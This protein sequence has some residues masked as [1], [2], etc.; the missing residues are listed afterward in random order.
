V[1]DAACTLSGHAREA[2]VGATP[3]IFRSGRHDRAFFEHMWSTI[4]SGR[5]WRGEI[6]NRRA[7]GTVCPEEMTITPVRDGTG[8]IRHYVAVKQDVTDRRA[9][10]EA[11][12]RSNEELQQALLDL[13]A[14]ETTVIRQERLRALGSLASGVAHDFNNALTAILGYSEM[15]LRRPED[16]SD[17]ETVRRN[18]AV[19]RDAAHDAGAVVARLREFYRPPDDSADLDSVDL[20][21]VVRGAVTLS[22]PRWKNEA[23]ARGVRVSV[24]VEGEGPALVAG[25]PAELREAVLNLILNAV[26]ALPEGGEIVLRTS[27]DGARVALDVEDTGVGMTD[28]ARARC[29]E[30]FFSTKGDRGTGLGLAMVHGIVR[31]HGGTID[32]ESERGAGTRF[33]LVFPAAATAGPR[34][35]QDAGPEGQRLRILVVD[36]DSRT[37]TVV[38]AYLDSLGHEPVAAASADDAL[39]TFMTSRIDL[40]VIDRA[41]PGMNGDLLASLLR[42][43]RPDLP[44]IMLTGFGSM[45]RA[46][47]DAPTDVDVVLGKPAKIGDL[48]AAIAEA[49]SRHPASAPV[50]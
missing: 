4:S 9:A 48:R 20:A 15:L 34:A 46:A 41:M 14:A 49:T 21:E 23:E 11:L 47:L 16:L 44:I 22:Q 10:E 43:G 36:D 18:L 35:S 13:K 31:R 45:M 38:A 29:F 28:E 27:G 5:V 17:P 25:R 30:P 39:R 7:D 6:E 40:A 24:R 3:R 2:L 37:R 42:A 19:I 32:L 50:A 33:R 12:H 8:A 1:N 26:D